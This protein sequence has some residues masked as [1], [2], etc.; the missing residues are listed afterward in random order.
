M[1]AFAAILLPAAV[2]AT[3]SL[4]RSPGLGFLL[5]IR[6][7]WSLRTTT[8]TELGSVAV[9]SAKSPTESAPCSL[10][11]WR[12]N[13]CATLS[14]RPPKVWGS[15][16]SRTIQRRAS[17]TRRTSDSCSGTANW[18]PMQQASTLLGS[19]ASPAPRPPVPVPLGNLRPIRS[20][21]SMSR[22]W[23]KVGG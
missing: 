12:T 10:R 18:D 8:D 3:T 21:S 22:G 14:S 9:R 13:I 2:K 16:S 5:T 19:R 15:L 17:N 7:S 11:T 4:R 20:I 6:F 23:A 1:G